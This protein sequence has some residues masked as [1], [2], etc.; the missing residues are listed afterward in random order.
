[1]LFAV[2][3]QYADSV[4]AHYFSFITYGCVKN[5]Q[6]NQQ[7]TEK[8]YFFFNLCMLSVLCKAY[9]L[10]AISYLQGRTFLQYGQCATSYLWKSY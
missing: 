5:I 1:M 6:N 4:P 7:N 8:Y 2:L 9:I 10:I 3:I